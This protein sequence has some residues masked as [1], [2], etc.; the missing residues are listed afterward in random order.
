MGL[1]LLLYLGILFVGIFTGYKE[2]SHKRLLERMDQLQI[3]LV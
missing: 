1:R 3:L 2:I